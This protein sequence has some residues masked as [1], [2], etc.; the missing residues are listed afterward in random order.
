MNTFVKF[1][2][3]FLCGYQLPRC[4]HRPVILFRMVRNYKR[5]TDRANWSEDQMKL[6]ILAVESKDLSIR[7]ASVVFGV[8]KDSLNRRVKGKLKSLSMDEKH[9]NILGR[10][11][12]ILT[13]DQEKQLEDH[14]ISM[15]Q[16]FY[17]LSINDIRTIVYDYCEKNNIKNNF[18][19][20]NKMAGRDFVAGFMKR[21][22]KLSLR[23]PESVSV[24]R[25]F[26]LNKTSVNLYFN[27]L[28]TVLNKHNFKPHEIFNCDETG[29]TCVH[30]PVKV[31]APKERPPCC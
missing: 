20:D 1:C 3:S 18:N 6:A 26:G 5:K 19:S 24:N 7:E 29:L 22:P 21:H 11:R 12:A 30:K 14:I 25:V 31:I 10:Y 8:P 2:Q 4:L 16:A 23:R 27:N 13:H 15:D 28:E 17:G 9:K